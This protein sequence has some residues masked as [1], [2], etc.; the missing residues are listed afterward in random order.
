MKNH[1]KNKLFI[2]ISILFVSI[3]CFAGNEISHEKPKNYIRPEM[4]RYNEYIRIKRAIGLHS[5]DAMFSKRARPHKELVNFLEFLKNEGHDLNEYDQKNK[6]DVE[7]DRC[8]SLAKF[9]WPLYCE[10]HK[11]LGYGHINKNDN[12]NRYSEFDAIFSWLEV[13]N[14]AREIDKRNVA[15]FVKSSDPKLKEYIEFLEV[16]LNETERELEVL[17]NE[18]DRL[19]KIF[20]DCN[21][22]LRFVMS[23]HSIFDELEQKM[24]AMIIEN[25]ENARRAIYVNACDD[26]KI[27]KMLI[28]QRDSV[29]INLK[30][31]QESIKRQLLYMYVVGSCIIVWKL[32]NI[33]SKK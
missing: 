5:K 26:E 7:H 14:F 13:R 32:C 11:E 4:S 19:R 23:G 8:E 27:A 30:E 20:D 29:F 18:I 15:Q 1:M 33:L 25:E 9:S 10:M 31:Q 28:I 17:K 3:A 24:R 12:Y 16:E 22:R 2:K 6:L 21:P